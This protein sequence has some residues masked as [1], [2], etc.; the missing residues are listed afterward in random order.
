MRSQ[1]A[2]PRTGRRRGLTFVQ[3]SAPPGAGKRPGQYCRG[4]SPLEGTDHVE[5]FIGSALL[6]KLLSLFRKPAKPSAQHT[7]SET[8]AA[9]LPSWQTTRG[10]KLEFDKTLR[11]DTETWLALLPENERPTELCAAYPRIVNRFAMIWTNR[12]AVRSYFDDLLI[13]KRGGRIGFTPPIK[14]ELTRLRAHY[15]RAMADAAAIRQW[16]ERM[17]NAAG[18]IA[19]PKAKE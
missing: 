8:R 4:S 1:W 6:R 11:P 2:N 12:P 13:D 18:S 14:D 5:P 19:S 10:P 17:S 15:E 7:V 3:A 9:A 16:K